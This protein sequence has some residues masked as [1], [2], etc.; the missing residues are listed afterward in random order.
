[1]HLAV[2]SVS[3][4]ENSG[5]SLETGVVNI[6]DL[7]QKVTNLFMDNVALT[8]KLR[9]SQ[10]VETEQKESIRSLEVRLVQALE[11]QVHPCI[12]HRMH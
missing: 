3:Q 12:S 4:P 6:K 10:E 5:T 8:T 2:S 1:M 11:K 7:E 9:A